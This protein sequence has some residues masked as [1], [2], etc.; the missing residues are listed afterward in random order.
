MEFIISKLL[1]GMKISSEIELGIDH[2]EYSHTT[3]LA[4][5]TIKS[6]ATDFN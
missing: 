4:D 2:S 3:K 5:T 1:I 6:L